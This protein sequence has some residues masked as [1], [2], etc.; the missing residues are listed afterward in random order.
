M[1]EK[2]LERN[3]AIPVEQ[4]RIFSTSRDDQTEVRI[5][6]VQGEARRADEN[7]PLGELVVSELRAAPRGEVEIIVT[8]EVDTNGILNVTARDYKSGRICTKSVKISGELDEPSVAKITLKSDNH[9]ELEIID[10]RAS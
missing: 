1:V 10:E 4:S 7:T 5:R 6:I 2:V 8:F 9:T 3:M